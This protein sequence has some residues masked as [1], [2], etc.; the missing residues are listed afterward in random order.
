MDLYDPL[1]IPPPVGEPEPFASLRPP[2]Y[3]GSLQDGDKRGDDQETE[4]EKRR[5]LLGKLQETA[6]PQTR[7]YENFRA[8]L[9]VE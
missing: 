9:N 7:A 8:N 6:E 1:Y 2:F 5:A 3:S 4:I